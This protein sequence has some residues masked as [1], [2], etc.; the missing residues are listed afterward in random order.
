MLDSASKR[1]LRQ[2]AH[3]LKPVVLVGQH[4]LS[5]AVVAEIDRALIDHELIKVKFRGLERDER[6]ETVQRVA[7]ELNADVVST[8][9]G[10]AVIYRKNPESPPQRSKR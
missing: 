6:A 7:T 9:G 1:K 8:I 4:G 5:S 10:T 3:H 2:S